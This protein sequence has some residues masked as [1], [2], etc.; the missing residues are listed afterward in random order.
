MLVSSSD[1]LSLAFGPVYQRH[2]LRGSHSGAPRGRKTDNH[3]NNSINKS[4]FEGDEDRHEIPMPNMLYVVETHFDVILD[5]KSLSISFFMHATLSLSL[6]LIVIH[7]PHFLYEIFL[8]TILM[9]LWLVCG[10]SIDWISS[11]SD[12]I[13]ILVSVYIWAEHQR[14]HK[15][16]PISKCSVSP[17][18]RTT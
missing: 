5:H 10:S 4:R 3:L 18:C 9:I 14:S 6:S 15:R 7:S 17:S 16:R 13:P 2:T 12:L 11:T 1:D 8:Y